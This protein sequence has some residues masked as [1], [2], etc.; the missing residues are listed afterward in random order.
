M[1]SYQAF[2][3]R[4]KI[5][6]RRWEQKVLQEIFST[7]GRP[8]SSFQDRQLGWDYVLENKLVAIRVRKLQPWT[9]QARDVV[10]RLTGKGGRTDVEV[11]KLLARRI[12]YYVY[13]TV[14]EE[15][16]A[17]VWWVLF[18]GRLLADA[19]AE[20]LILLTTGRETEVEVRRN[21]QGGSFLIVPISLLKPAIL[22]WYK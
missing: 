20:Q 21:E 4:K 15:K 22:R 1:T 17:I 5:W 2:V 7:Q 3:E 13:A 16:N 18:W 6:A 9:K 19:L 11:R 8:S 12:D 10:F 14:D